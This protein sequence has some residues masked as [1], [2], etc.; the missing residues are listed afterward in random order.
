[1]NID[2]IKIKMKGRNI[3]TL[4]HI[5][6]NV[7]MSKCDFATGESVLVVREEVFE[8]LERQN[9]LMSNKTKELQEQNKI[10]REALESIAF[11]DEPLADTYDY[12]SKIADKSKFPLTLASDTDIAREA[13]AKVKE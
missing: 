11:Y 8:K 5:Y 4:T 3:T 10:M 7:D 13:L 1:M 12:W 2:S 9:K 6:S